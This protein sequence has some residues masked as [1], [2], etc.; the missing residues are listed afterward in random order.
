MCALLP[1][2][3]LM[4]LFPKVYDPGG[5]PLSFPS[6]LH[7]VSQDI[8]PWLCSLNKLGP[9]MEIEVSLV[10]HHYRKPNRQSL[11]RRVIMFTSDTFSCSRF[12]SQVIEIK[13][14]STDKT[15]GGTWYYYG[16]RVQ[17]RRYSWEWSSVSTDTVST[18]IVSIAIVENSCK[19]WLIPWH[20]YEYTKNPCVHKK[21][22]IKVGVEGYHSGFNRGSAHPNLFRFFWKVT[23]GRSK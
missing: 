10:S 2:S 23:G 13:R 14:I 18:C 12:I 20:V 11:Q 19:A 3:I 16:N 17:F 22:L 7:E 4:I 15:F 5:K 21:I 6:L 8:L 9:W 1:K